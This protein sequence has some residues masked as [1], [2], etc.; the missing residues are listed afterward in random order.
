MSGRKR[1]HRGP[2][3]ETVNMMDPKMPFCR[4]ARKN[5]N[6]SERRFN[7]QWGDHAE[8]SRGP[9][10]KHKLQTDTASFI[11]VVSRAE[12]ETTVR[13]TVLGDMIDRRS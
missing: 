6:D 7:V 3:E 13:L 1:V 9:A 2:E 5:N 11:F 10:V 12:G 8:A 4:Q